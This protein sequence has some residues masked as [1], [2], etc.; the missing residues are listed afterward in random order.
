MY[1]LKSNTANSEQ[2]TLGA[3]KAPADVD[4]LVVTAALAWV[5]V[6]WAQEAV[7]GQ[8]DAAC[9]HAVVVGM[10]R[11]GTADAAGQTTCRMRER[12][13]EKEREREGDRE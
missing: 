12:G 11:N 10:V 6:V 13:R 2:L 3:H 9:G 5:E 4:V 7:I 1:I 8:G